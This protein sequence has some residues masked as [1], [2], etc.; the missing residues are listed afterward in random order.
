MYACPWKEQ[1]KKEPPGA[2]LLIAG[3]G[4]IPWLSVGT[5][6]VIVVVAVTVIGVIGRAGKSRTVGAKRGVPET[7]SGE[8][9][10]CAF[11]PARKMN[12]KLF[13]FTP[14]R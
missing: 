2:P 8:K 13:E 7:S 14:R 4:L 9:R 6:V 3:C 1:K 5:L 10:R 12:E 11:Q